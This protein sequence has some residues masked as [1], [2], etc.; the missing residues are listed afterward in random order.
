MFKID[1]NSIIKM[2][3]DRELNRA[4]EITFNKDSTYT[5]SGVL[6][7]ISLNADVYGDAGKGKHIFKSIYML[8]CGNTSV[9][10]ASRSYSDGSPGLKH[11]NEIKPEEWTNTSNHDSCW[12]SDGF[13]FLSKLYFNM[14]ECVAPNVAPIKVDTSMSL[15]ICSYPVKHVDITLKSADSYRYSIVNVKYKKQGV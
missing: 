7:D 9:F 3:V 13:N 1:G 5:R 4:S 11:L 10:W 8:F 15:G 14:C 2:L 6:I 12:R